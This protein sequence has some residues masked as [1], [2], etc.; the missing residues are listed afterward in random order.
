M[1]LLAYAH[2]RAELPAGDKANP[3]INKQ[4]NEY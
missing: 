3:Q 4:I 1:G 2:A